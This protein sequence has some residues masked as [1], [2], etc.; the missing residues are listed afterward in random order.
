[1][2]IILARHGQPAIRLERTTI[3]RESY[4]REIRMGLERN[5]AGRVNSPAIT[6]LKLLDL[7]CWHRAKRP[8]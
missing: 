7:A 8:E 1:M 5:P 3:D 2:A 6:D 4:M